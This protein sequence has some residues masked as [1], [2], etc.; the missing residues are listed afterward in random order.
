MG[1]AGATQLINPLVGLLSDRCTSLWGRR[2]PFILIGGTV[3]IAGILAQDFAS[4][5]SLPTLYYFAYGTSMLALNTAY[6]AVVGI[7]ADLI[8]TSQTGTAT[9][10]SALQTVLGAN[11]GFFAYYCAGGTTEDHLHTM[12]MLY[13]FVGFC[14]VMLT[15]YSAHEVPLGQAETAKENCEIDKG[16]EDLSHL[17][18][19]SSDW[20]SSPLKRSDIIGAY[21]IDPRKHRDFTIVFW[22]RT[23][24]YFGCSVQTFF[25]Y[26]LKDVL[27]IVDVEASIVKV[28]VIGQITAAITAIPSGYISDRLGGMR[29]PFIYGA[30]FMLA[31]GNVANCFVRDESHVLAIGGFLGLGNGVYLAMDAALALDT[32]PSGEDAARF[33]GV[34]GIGCFL[35]G[36][37]G[38]LLAGPILVLCGESPNNPGEYDYSGYAIVLSGAAMAFM[39]SGYILKYVRTRDHEQP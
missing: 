22:S 38:P 34:W 13:V 15:V 3:G 18:P 1:I 11:A 31:V 23:L 39:F 17:F 5:H 35:G 24:Y 2:R 8:P 7:M 19:I 6:T 20:L 28:A 25:K 9:G 27:G 12:Y 26:Y 16:S 14:T 33:M 30:C 36:A 32:L 37:V 29:K 10:I 21:Y 4:G